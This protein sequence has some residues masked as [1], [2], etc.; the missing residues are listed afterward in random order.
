[1]PHYLPKWVLRRLS[2]LWKDFQAKDF[3]FEQ[4]Q[5][6]LED[7]SRIVN[8]ILSQLKNFG[9]IDS[10]PDPSDSRRKIYKII[11]SDIVEK[12][13]KIEIEAR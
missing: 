7:D 12:M 1:M 9:W 6:A 11:H 13:S 8:L 10:R 4:A 5:N 3:T 2:I